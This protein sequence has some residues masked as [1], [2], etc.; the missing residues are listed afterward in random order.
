MQQHSGQSVVHQAEILDTMQTWC[1]GL[2][3]KILPGAALTWP[4]FSSISATATFPFFSGLSLKY[5]I[6][7]AL[8]T[9]S[10]NLLSVDNLRTSSSF[11]GVIP[12]SGWHTGKSSGIA[13]TNTQIWAWTCCIPFFWLRQRCSDL[14]APFLPCLAA[15]ISQFTARRLFSSLSFSS[16]RIKKWW[17]SWNT[18]ER[19]KTIDSFQLLWH[20]SNLKLLNL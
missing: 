2:R 20:K 5:I 12:G 17:P 4:T 8:R 19:Q 16:A 6:I 15:L 18:E 3:V 14:A 7:A 9:A 13:S 1:W 11:S 10:S